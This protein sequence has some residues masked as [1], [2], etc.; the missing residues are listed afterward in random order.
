MFRKDAFSYDCELYDLHYLGSVI[1]QLRI[2]ASRNIALQL[3]DDPEYV[4]EEIQEMAKDARTEAILS[5]DILRKMALCDSRIDLHTCASTEVHEVYNQGFVFYE[6]AD[7]DPSEYD[8]LNIL[9]L[10]N[11]Y[12]N[13]FLWDNIN[14]R[15]VNSV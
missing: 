6:P 10:I 7:I 1:P 4:P 14:G 11:K 3:E 2:Y 8:V 12:V 13:G 5:D 9:L 15:R